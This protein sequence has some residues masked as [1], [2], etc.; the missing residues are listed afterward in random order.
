MREIGMNWLTPPEIAM[1]GCST[2]IPVETA[3]K[4]FT[5]VTEDDNT[6]TLLD[7]ENVFQFGNSFENDDW[8][9]I[10]NFYFLD[11][12]QATCLYSYA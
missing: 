4:L 8:S 11:K 2:T 5:P 6:S 10:E 3:V 1:S 12:E 7:P 9:S